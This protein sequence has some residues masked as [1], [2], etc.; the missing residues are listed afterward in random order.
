MKKISETLKIYRDDP[1]N[2]SIREAMGTYAG[3][4]GI[5]SNVFL[6]AVKMAVGMLSGSISIIADAI[7]NLSDSGS[8]LM[9]IIGF[10]LAS[11]P[12]D[13]EHPFGHERMEY[14]SRTFCLGGDNHNRL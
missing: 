5:M 14:L 2:P 9:T 1:R 3:A 8:S 12:A 7:N 6:F 13:K 4:V 10:K 11:K